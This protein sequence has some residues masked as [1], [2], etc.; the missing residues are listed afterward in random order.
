MVKDVEF[1]NGFKEKMED[2]S[3]LANSVYAEVRENLI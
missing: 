3:D 1:V 2:I